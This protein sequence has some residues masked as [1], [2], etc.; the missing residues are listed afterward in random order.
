MS[1]LT[2][3]K[4]QSEKSPSSLFDPAEHHG[5]Y[6]NFEDGAGPRPWPGSSRLALCPMWPSPSP[7]H[8]QPTHRGPPVPCWTSAGPC[9]KAPKAAGPRPPEHP[10]RCPFQGLAT[11]CCRFPLTLRNR[12][13]PC[14]GL[15]KPSWVCP[16]ASWALPLF[17]SPAIHTARSHLVDESRAL[18]TK[19]TL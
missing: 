7:R 14:S 4:E 19:S 6:V 5:A 13:P 15:Q 1:H 16:S 3:V 10:H 2:K 18:K 11:S 9:S 17:S 12:R 8:R